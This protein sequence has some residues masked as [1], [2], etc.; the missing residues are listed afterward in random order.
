M[1]QINHDAKTQKEAFPIILEEKVS[2]LRA[3][4]N[5]RNN[6]FCGHEGLHLE[7]IQGYGDHRGG[8]DIGEPTFW[9]LFVVCPKCDNAMSLWKLGVERERY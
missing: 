4:F 2:H 9:W 5:K 3:Q 7:P 1:L 8:Y 6:C